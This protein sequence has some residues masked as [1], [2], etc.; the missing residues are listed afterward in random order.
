MCPPGLTSPVFRTIQEYFPNRAHVALVGN[1]FSYTQEL[2]HASPLSSQIVRSFPGS[3][4]GT[5]C[6]GGSA[7]RAFE[8]TRVTAGKK[9]SEQDVGMRGKCRI[10][11]ELILNRQCR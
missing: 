6:L 5:R 7:S 9:A 2:N 1:E 11:L 10:N 8:S 4:L 3:R